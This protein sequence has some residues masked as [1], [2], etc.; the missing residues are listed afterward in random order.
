GGARSGKSPAV[1]TAALL[2]PPTANRP[3][4]AIAIHL[5]IVRLLDYCVP[6]PAAGRA[7]KRHSCASPLTSFPIVAYDD[8]SRARGHGGNARSPPTR[9]GC[10]KRGRCQRRTRVAFRAIG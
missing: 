9:Q 5:H 6:R 1:S 3:A 7:R 4:R 10:C 2:H 8:L